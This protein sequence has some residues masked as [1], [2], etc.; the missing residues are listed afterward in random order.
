MKKTL[1]YFHSTDSMPLK[2]VEYILYVETRWCSLFT[3]LQSA[4]KSRHT[5][6]QAPCSLNMDISSFSMSNEELVI[7]KKVFA[8]P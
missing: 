2:P 6:I 3:M 4:I 7:V 5:I 8:M 1:M